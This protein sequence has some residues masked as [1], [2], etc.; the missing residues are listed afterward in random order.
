MNPNSDAGFGSL[1]DFTPKSGVTVSE[2]LTV[3]GCVALKKSKGTEQYPTA[4]LVHMQKST[5]CIR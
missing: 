3:R 2:R 1:N 4:F 5:A